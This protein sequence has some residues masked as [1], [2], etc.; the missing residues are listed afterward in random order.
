MADP[1]ECS[2]VVTG[3]N[4]NWGGDFTMRLIRA[5]RFNATALLEQGASFEVILV[6]WNPV[7]DR[8]LLSAVVRE[9]LGHMLA[10]RSSARLRPGT[11]DV[12]RTR[13]SGGTRS[14]TCAGAAALCRRIRRLRAARSRE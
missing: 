2:I 7:I 11:R 4:D 3:R 6:E 5:G 12:G 9:E 13:G 1:V 8:P 14:G 10:G